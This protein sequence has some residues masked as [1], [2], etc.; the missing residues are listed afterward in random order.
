[1]GIRLGVVLVVSLFVLSACGDSGKVDVGARS[2]PDLDGTSWIAT[3]I[4]E[5]GNPRA[6]VP[7]SELRVGFADGR[8]NIDAGCNKMSGTYALSEKAELTTKSLT[9]TEMACAQALMDQ[10]AW[11]SGTAFAKPL[12]ASVSGQALTLSRDGLELKLGDRATLSPDALL[13]G[14]NWQ[15]NGIQTGETVASLAAGAHVPT[16]TIAGDGSM[17]L[18]TGCNTGRGTISVDGAKITF[19]P[20]ITTRKACPDKAG[21]QTEAAVLA[22]LTGTADWMISESTL[23]ITNGGRALIYRAAS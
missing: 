18:D 14:T 10:D 16:M 19:G 3:A 21:R 2:V 5:N 11:I 1:M 13:E 20:V 4:T 12:I 22:V 7:G 9:G 6:I 15:L 17:V 8:I 23:T